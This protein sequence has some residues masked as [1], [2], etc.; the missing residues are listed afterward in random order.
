MDGK[1]DGRGW[2]LS[3]LIDYTYVD[4]ILFI[5]NIIRCEMLVFETVSEA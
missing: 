2:I 4:Y 3:V 5:Y 1:V